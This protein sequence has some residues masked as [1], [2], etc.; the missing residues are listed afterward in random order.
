MANVSA[1]H[2]TRPQQSTHTHTHTPIKWKQSHLLTQSSY[3]L[4]VVLSSPQH[5]HVQ[6]S[7]V[8]QSLSCVWLCVTTLLGL[9]TSSTYGVPLPTHQPQHRWPQLI[10]QTQYQC[11]D[12]SQTPWLGRNG[13]IGVV[14]NNGATTIFMIHERPSQT[15]FKSISLFTR[16]RK[17]S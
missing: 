9:S 12:R 17:L 2:H 7:L 4:V 6:A 10:L 11:L 1:I 14:C 15:P 16:L 13:G 3:V 8:C 5:C